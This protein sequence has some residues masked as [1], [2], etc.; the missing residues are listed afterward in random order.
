MCRDWTVDRGAPHVT[1][2]EP[3]IHTFP[4]TSDVS[5]I[6]FDDPPWAQLFLEPALTTL[7]QP[8]DLLGSTAAEML[9]ERVTHRYEEPARRLVVPPELILRKSVGLPNA[10][11]PKASATPH[12]RK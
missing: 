12:S 9:L 7:R 4:G 6:A 1:R 3:L 2:K 11:S 10:S 5:L 8:T